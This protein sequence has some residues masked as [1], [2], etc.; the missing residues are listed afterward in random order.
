MLVS[1]SFDRAK[2]WVRQRQGESWLSWSVG[3]TP[4]G[5]A[6]HRCEAFRM[7]RCDPDRCASFPPVADDAT[8]RPQSKASVLF[9]KTRI[10]SSR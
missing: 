1:G 6:M 5:C 4:V 9:P 7:P 8:S 3:F 10:L 2:P